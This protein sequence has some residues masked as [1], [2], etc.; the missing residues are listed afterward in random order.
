MKFRFLSLVAVFLAIAP[1]PTALSE[2]LHA[3]SPL[4]EYAGSAACAECH[5]DI[6]E[7]WSKRLKASF[8]R[9]RKDIPGDIPGDWE[10]S[11]FSKD[12]VFL[13]VGKKRKAAFVDDS[14]KMLPAEYHLKK[15]KWMERRNWAKS[16]IDY[17]RQCAVCHTVGASTKKLH[18]KELN[19]GCETCHG[20]ARTHVDLPETTKVRV[21]G[22][23][24]NKDVID[25]CKKCH[26]NRKKHARA[27]QNFRGIFHE[28]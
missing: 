27:L 21:P 14:W 17:R 13:V 7:K 11:P 8:V 20:P 9:Y 12:K 28:K 6:Y 16:N 1:I 25:T 18:F 19:I 26:N 24:D 15:E 4:E 23:T 10:N 2:G 5:T 3:E 22:K